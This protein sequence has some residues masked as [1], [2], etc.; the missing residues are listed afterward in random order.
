[1]AAR[2]GQDVATLETTLG[3]PFADGALL[4]TALTHV[5]AV[6]GDPARSNQRLE[7]LGDRVLGLA[8]ADMVMEAY[9]AG[10]EGDLSRRLAALVR[11]ETCAEV[12]L[13][14]EIGPHLKLGG[15]AGAMRKNPSVLGDA[16]EAVIGAVYLDGGYEA[17]RELVR[18][19]FGGRLA[20]LATP[21]SN[22][23]AELQEWAAAKGRPPPTYAIVAR[24]GPDH[25]PHF[26]VAV[27]VEAMEEARGKGPSR[28][29]AEQ[30]AALAL[31]VREGVARQPAGATAA[32]EEESADA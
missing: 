4:R 25:A 31:L 7:F 18:R 17:A 13:A 15:G 27:Q 21:P 22:P 1:M 23:K 12:A 10:S 8:V 26:V 32:A 14:W 11:R 30:D 24:S 3:H 2:R 6:A 19:S 29:V 9:P 5:S 20:E 28:R 16:C